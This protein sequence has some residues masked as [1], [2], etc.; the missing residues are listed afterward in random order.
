MPSTWLREEPPEVDA[1]PRRARV[2]PGRGAALERA[3]GRRARSRRCGRRRRARAAPDPRPAGTRRSRAQAR[4]RA[5]V[6][7]RRVVARRGGLLEGEL[8]AAVADDAVAPELLAVLGLQVRVAAV[9]LLPVG[10]PPDPGGD[11]RP[12]LVGA[13]LRAALGRRHPDAG[14][15]DQDQRR[16]H[17]RWP[18]DCRTAE[19]TIRGRASEGAPAPPCGVCCCGRRSSPTRPTASRSRPTRCSPGA[20]APSCGWRPPS[21]STP[22][23]RCTGSARARS[24]AATRSSSPPSRCA[25]RSRRATS[26]SP[27][28][29]GRSPAASTTPTLVAVEVRTEARDAVADVEGAAATRSTSSCTPAARCDRVIATPELDAERRLRAVRARRRRLVRAVAGR[30]APAQPRAGRPARPALVPRR[31]PRPA[32]RPATGVAGRRGDRASRSR[33]ASPLQRGG[34]RA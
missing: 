7:L 8:H 29:A 3:S 4:P 18:T 28:C 15:H 10:Q 12:R 22:R 32:R 9:G 25:W 33:R 17:R 1:A 30:A 31:H 24:A 16:R 14:G 34:G 6:G 11:R 13:D 2:E 26:P 5:A 23:A 27:R 20:R 21:A 19:P